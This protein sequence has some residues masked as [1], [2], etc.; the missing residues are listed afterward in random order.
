[1][2]GERV[3][4]CFP[5]STGVAERREQDRNQKQKRGSGGAGPPTGRCDMVVV[6]GERLDRI[7]APRGVRICEAAASKWSSAR[8]S[9]AELKLFDARGVARQ[10]LSG[11]SARFS[12]QVDALP[13]DGARQSPRGESEPPDPIFGE[14]GTA[15]RLNWLVS[16]KRFK[17]TP[18][19]FLT[20][21]SLYLPRQACQAR[22]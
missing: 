12:S 15:L 1:R 13:S 22:N 8:Q 2:A 6:H 5:W 4:G 16:R 18:S 17:K 14:F 10:S 20:S 3:I 7:G 21:R 11:T 19:H 9:R